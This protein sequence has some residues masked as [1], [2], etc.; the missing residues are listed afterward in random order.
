VNDQPIIV[1]K[2]RKVAA[3]H[4]GGSWKVAFADFMTAMMAF[5][6]VMWI[7][8][9]DQD[10]RSAIAGYFQDPLD[11]MK[12]PS[13]RKM[14]NILDK[15]PASIDKGTGARERDV[16]S[17]DNERTNLDK[18]QHQIEEAVASEPDAGELSKYVKIQSTEEG[19]QLEFVESA[20]NMFFE[21]GSAIVRPIARKLFLK[22]G[23]ILGDSKHH[24]V[25]DGHTDSRPYSEG[26]RYNNWD[27]SQDRA[28]A[29]RR[30][31]VEGGLSENQVLACRGFA[32]KRLRNRINPF[33]YSNRRVSV[34]LPYKSKEE[35]VVGSQPSAGPIQ[36]I[37]NPRIDIVSGKTGSQ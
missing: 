24:I 2:I 6:L 17:A 30:V 10:T 34:L 23:K 21:T 16:R 19:L 9:L 36:G 29:T 8:G 22:V 33:D 25:V 28:G 35:A 37:V 26:A 15:M 27:L 5:F 32:D 18:I 3:A 12:K 1:K 20:G 13:G 14:A 4:H 31:L 7:I 11:F